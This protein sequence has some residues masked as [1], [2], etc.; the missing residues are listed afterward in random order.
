MTL[1]FGNPSGSQPV[2][3]GNYFPVALPTWDGDSQGASDYQ[4]N[5]AHCNGVP[6]AID[7]EII[8]EPGAMV[9]PTAHGMDNL[10]AQDPN[11]T[12]DVAT[13]SV[14]NSCAQAA[15]PCAAISPRIVAIP[16]FDTG[17]FHEGKQTG[18]TQLRIVNILGF[19]INSMQ[20][21]DVSGVFMRIPG[22]L[23]AGAG[24]NVNP[25]AAFMQVPLLVR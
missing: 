7:T 15:T 6:V 22:V 8:S 3:P 13:Q 14:Q 24:A 23:V 19:F 17:W 21:Q 5:I 18:R 20:G 16:I 4:N 2:A 10:I 11:A 25:N 12:W 1:K 9:G